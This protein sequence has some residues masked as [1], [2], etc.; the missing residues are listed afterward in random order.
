M[1]TIRKRG[2]TWAV[3]VRRRGQAPVYKTFTSR[4]AADRWA[5]QVE[6][7]MD[8]GTFVD[9][10]EAE[11]TILSEALD[12]YARERT[13]LKKGAVQET[14]RIKAWQRDPMAKLALTALRS[15]DI[16]AWRDRQIAAGKAP[17]TI[18][19]M[20]SV[21]SQVYKLAASEW[22]LEGLR[23]PV[24]GVRMPSQ[25]PGRD[26]RLQGDEEA[27]LLAAA[28]QV[29]P[30]LRPLITLALETAM[31]LGELLAL[32]RSNIRGAVAHLS[33]TK[34]GRARAVPL[35]TRALA[36]VRVLPLAMDGRII[37]LEIDRVEY[38]WRRSCRLAEIEGLRFHDLRHEATSR[39]FESGKFELMEVAAVT[40]HRTL[41]MLQRYTHLKA[42]DLGQEARLSL[43]VQAPL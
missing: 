24:R 12:R 19:N 42:A 6:G 31:R 21:L 4:A 30:Y 27:R 40:G 34:N 15:A 39:L 10:R 33:D 1:A 20:L 5:R 9:L 13:P 3:A 16:A 17:S 2:S 43:R 36:A 26:R 38:A 11:R 14:N 32:K 7:Q 23:N 22:H 41:N 25:R 29:E 28:D 18:R 35:S 8:L 37:P